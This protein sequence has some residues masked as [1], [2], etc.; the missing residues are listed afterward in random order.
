VPDRL[1]FSIFTDGAGGRYCHRCGEYGAWLP[2]GTDLAA[3]A[4]GHDR[5]ERAARA[6][7]ARARRQTVTARL[8]LLNHLRREARR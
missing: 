8:R 4:R 7:D 3:H 6:R 2:V 1:G 5:E